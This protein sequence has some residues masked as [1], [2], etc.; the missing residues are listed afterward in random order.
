MQTSADF[1]L[2]LL[3]FVLAMSVFKA[4]S[5]FTPTNCGNVTILTAAKGF[6]HTPNFPKAFPLPIRCRWVIDKTAF[7]PQL[8][9]TGNATQIYIYLTQLFVTSGLNITEYRVYD[10]ES[11]TAYTENVHLDLSATDVI[12]NGTLYVHT[13]NYSF[14]V[15]DFVL[16]M[17]EG[18]HLRVM[19][20]LMDV[21]G[22]NITYEI[23]KTARGD[24]DTCTVSECSFLGHCYASADFS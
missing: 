21:Y 4:K 14:M 11:N 22:F 2:L 15:I 6:I 16:D 20:N 1:A 5:T 23:S 10:E 7:E 8:G 17:L 12:S 3:L 24:N 18:N 19:D 13:V 9:D